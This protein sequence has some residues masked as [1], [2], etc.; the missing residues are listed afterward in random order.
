[1]VTISYPL[2]ARLGPKIRVIVPPANVS[3]GLVFG[4]GPFGI[5]SR[6]CACA[7]ASRFAL[8]AFMLP[9]RGSNC[10]PVQNRWP[11]EPSRSASGRS[12]W[13]RASLGLFPSPGPR[14]SPLSRMPYQPRAARPGTR[15]RPSVRGSNDYDGPSL[16]SWQQRWNIVVVNPRARTAPAA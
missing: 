5:A 11:L 4:S 15:I 9:S 1:M 2:R 10:Q 13:S 7:H 16:L 14:P 12:N 6:A 3:T 8:A